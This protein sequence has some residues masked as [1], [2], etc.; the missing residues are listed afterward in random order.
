MFNKIN[1]FRIF[2]YLKV[3]FNIS[4][5]FNIEISLIKFYI[6]EEFRFLLNLIKL[7]FHKIKKVKI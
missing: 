3:R 6:Y 7:S 5:C 4:N 2:C 1:I